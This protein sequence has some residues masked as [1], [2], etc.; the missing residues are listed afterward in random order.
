LKTICKY[1]FK[2]NIFGET[3]K[4]FLPSVNIYLTGYVEQLQEQQGYLNCFRN[5]VLLIKK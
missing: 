4:Q 3:A 2:N 5:S 1:V